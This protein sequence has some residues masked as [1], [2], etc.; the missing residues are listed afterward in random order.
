MREE[1]VLGS[2]K[3]GKE[4]GGREMGQNVGNRVWLDWE[5]VGLLR[6]YFVMF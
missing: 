3:R 4:S 5:Y 1:N 2:D 6:F